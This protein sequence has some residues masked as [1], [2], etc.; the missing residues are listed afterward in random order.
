V[1]LCLTAPLLFLQALEIPH[2][3][4]HFC[5]ASLGAEKY[6]VIAKHLLTTEPP[7]DVIRPK[8]DRQPLSIGDLALN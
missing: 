5:A 4:W 8:E 1:P 2:H 7:M 6:I 3:T